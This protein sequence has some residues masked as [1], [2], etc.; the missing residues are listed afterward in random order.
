MSN[1]GDCR[2][3]SVLEIIIAMAVF[4]LIMTAIADLMLGSFSTAMRGGELLQVQSLIQE[5]ME[6]VAAVADRA[7]NELGYASTSAV[8]DGAAWQL[9][10]DGFS[11]QIGNYTRIIELSPIYR[12]PDGHIV[13]ATATG[14]YLDVNSR[15]LRVE[16]KWPVKEE[17]Y[18]SH[19]SD[20]ILSN[21]KDAAWRQNDW[22]AGAGQAIWEES[23]KYDSDDANLA[24]GTG[25]LMLKEIATST[26]AQEAY[27]I[28]SAFNALAPSVFNSIEWRSILP[29]ECAAC[30]VRLQVQT[31]PDQN[32]TPGAWDQTWCG[33]EGE[34]GD[35]ED[36][37]ASS[38]G[39]IINKSHNG[40]QWI[41]YKMILVGD[42]IYT[43]VASEIRINYKPSQ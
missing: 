40:R 24:F 22:S 11:E 31:A 38:T 41:R 5:G 32:G 20:T 30:S 27:L 12:D 1:F 34:D 42:G 6:G 4:S 19:Y 7:W 23:D 15:G 18:L 39:M 21:W 26:Y 28:S 9:G 25:T 8:S 3:N 2:G 17:E 29:S 33:P 37:F 35:E 43:P 16:I 14:A 10:P 36:Y 13:T